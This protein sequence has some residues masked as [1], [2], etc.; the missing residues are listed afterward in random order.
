[1]VRAGYGTYGSWPA[2]S[3]IDGGT[4]NPTS[5]NF[6][7]ANGTIIPGGGSVGYANVDTPHA[8]RWYPACE[9]DYGWA[10]VP[11]WRLIAAMAWPVNPSL[12]ANPSTNPSNPGTCKISAL[13]QHWQLPYIQEWNIGIQHAFTSR[14]SLDVS[15]VGTHG[16]NLFGEVDLN[17][18]TPGTTSA[19]RIQESRPYFNQFPWMG[20]VINTSNLGF[21]N[22]NALQATLTQRGWRGI[23]NTVG[24]T[25]ASALDTAS[26]DVGLSVYTNPACPVQC[27]Y[28]P[29]FFDIRHRFTD[30]F[31]WNM[32][33]LKSPGQL[34]EGWSV[35]T[36]LNLQSG[37]PWDT[38]DSTD[39][40]SGTGENTD[41]WDIVGNASDFDGYGK[42]SN[43]PCYGVLGSKFGGS[44]ACTVEGSVNG[45][46]PQPCI[47]AANSL[48]VN[49]SVPSTDPGSTGIKQLGVYGCYMSGNSVILPPAQGTY[50]NMGKGIFTGQ[51]F[52][53]ADFSLRK[54]LRFKERLGPNSDSISSTSR[55]TPNTRYPADT[56]TAATNAIQTPSGFGRSA[57]TPN[58]SNG[59][60]IQGAGDARRY[61]FGLKFTF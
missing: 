1:M 57:S 12:P 31:T 23:T 53:I 19:S 21:S 14:M 44:G 7:Q 50:G 29:T 49:P 30:R 42:N 59:N 58:V 4:G 17:E 26:T 46:M 28:G 32:P 20:T 36:V 13:D 25:Y 6:Y 61:Q 54:E 2:W 11:E 37:I 39:N 48:P 38:R 18:A 16:T 33:G 41:K 8:H 43:I 10:H 22:Y 24:Y 55:T 3:V 60:V 27:N 56:G 5:A 34:L 45:Q 52:Q 9:L 51:P 35:S 40:I 47:N 15:Y